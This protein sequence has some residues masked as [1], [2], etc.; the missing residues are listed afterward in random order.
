MPTIA[1]CIILPERVTRPR[2]GHEPASPDKHLSTAGGSQAKHRTN[3]EELTLEAVEQRTRTA[4]ST[5]I[6]PDSEERTREAN[7]TKR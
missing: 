3:N 6:H 1:L 2:T 7:C 5:T 4:E